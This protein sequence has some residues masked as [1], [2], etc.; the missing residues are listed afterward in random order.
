MA[1]LTLK[2]LIQNTADNEVTKRDTVGHIVEGDIG[3]FT[4]NLSS[5]ID[6]QGVIKK[7]TNET[8]RI[9]IQIS[10]NKVDY[11]AVMNKEGTTILGWTDKIDEGFNG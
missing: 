9:G 8:V 1:D 11:T 10:M 5:R 4:G 3:F 7:Y 6:W 2:E